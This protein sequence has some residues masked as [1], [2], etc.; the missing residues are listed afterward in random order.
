MEHTAAEQNWTAHDQ[1]PHPLKKALQTPDLAI[2][3]GPPGS[4]KTST[5]LELV[6]Q[7]VRRGQRVLVCG[8]THVAVDNVLE[9]LIDDLRLP[10][11]VAAALVDGCVDL[12]TFATANLSRPELQQVAAR[13]QFQRHGSWLRSQA[14]SGALRGLRDDGT[15]L[16]KEILVPLGAPERPLEEAG[17][18][19][20]FVDCC[21]RARCALQAEAAQALAARLLSI[22]QEPSVAALPWN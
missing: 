11:T 14:V 7:L 8:S 22:A 4:G 19:R 21:A 6:L 2:L 16:R 9:R 20:K 18:V 1:K 10:F 15:G 3:E 17:L 12:D 5:I 13:V